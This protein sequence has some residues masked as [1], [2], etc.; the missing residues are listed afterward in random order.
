MKAAYS[1]QR[2]G[3]GIFI[4]HRYKVLIFAAGLFV[5][6]FFVL[7]KLGMEFLGTTEQNKFTIFIEL[8]TGAK[9]DAT[10][11]VVKKV[12]ALVKAKEAEI[13]KV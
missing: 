4:R 11:K 8:P 2:K 5:L 1:A 7:T 6:S 13:R 9:L 10:D 3:I 12:E